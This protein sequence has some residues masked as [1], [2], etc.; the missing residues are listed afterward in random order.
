MLNIISELQRMTRKQATNNMGKPGF[1][2][3][4][5]HQ[6]HSTNERAWKCR[7]ILASASL[8]CQSWEELEELGASSPP[9]HQSVWSK[10]V[11]PQV[12][13][14]PAEFHSSSV[15]SSTSCW[16]EGH[17]DWQRTSQL[18]SSAGVHSTTCLGSS[19]PLRWYTLLPRCRGR[20]DLR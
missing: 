17:S 13:S 16:T 2:Y 14:W 11:D 7:R 20:D 15:H 1:G 18:A 10:R 6:F 19:V 12:Q 4:G 9:S 8:G 3:F 5:F